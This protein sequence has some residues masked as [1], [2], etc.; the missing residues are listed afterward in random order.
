MCI[1]NR[2]GRRFNRKSALYRMNDLSTLTE[3]L[4][5]NLAYWRCLKNKNLHLAKLQRKDQ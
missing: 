1:L 3:I 5:E 4:L 2:K